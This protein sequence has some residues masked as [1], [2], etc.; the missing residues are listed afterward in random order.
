MHAGCAANLANLDQAARQRPRNSFRLWNR[1]HQQ[2]PSGGRG[3]WHRDL[4]LGI[5]IAAGAGIGFGPAMIEHIFTA[6]VA[7]QI[8]GRGRNQTA[9]GAAGQHVLGLPTG[10]RAD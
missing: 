7:L 8:A 9:V 6:R 10:A 4:Q 1:A 5:I 2:A 3:E